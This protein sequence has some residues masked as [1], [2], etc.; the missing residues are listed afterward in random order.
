MEGRGREGGGVSFPFFALV[1]SH[2]SLVYFGFRFAAWGLRGGSRGGCVRGGGGVGVGVATTFAPHH[3]PRKH[4]FA[5]AA[6]VQ[7]PW[8]A[9]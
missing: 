6:Q 7:G 9:W 5:Y 3:R 1:V 4:T 2:L 8:A